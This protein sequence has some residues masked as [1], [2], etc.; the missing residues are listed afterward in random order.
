[1]ERGP[2]SGQPREGAG[3]RG[4]DRGGEHLADHPG[5]PQGQCGDDRRCR[6][7]RRA[8]GSP[9]STP[10]RTPRP[11]GKTAT[12]NPATVA[13]ATLPMT[14]G[15]RSGGNAA[16]CHRADHRD[17]AQAQQDPA[18]RP[19][20]AGPRAS[21]RRE[22]RGRASGPTPGNGTLTS[23]RD[24]REDLGSTTTR[25]RDREPGQPIK[26]GHHSQRARRRNPE[27]WRRSAPRRP[28]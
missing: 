5:Q 21:S 15:H 2:R 10:S 23:A 13:S 8:P 17:L 20:R 11:P 27:R 12:T 22:N 28:S 24:P 6:S 26:T 1:M 4:E 18:R 16:G 19:T 3:E 9:S 7:R 14:N 25:K